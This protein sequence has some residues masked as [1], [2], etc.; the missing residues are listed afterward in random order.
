MKKL[1]MRVLTLCM[2]LGMLVGCQQDNNDKKTYLLTI[3]GYTMYDMAMLYFVSTD[4]EVLETGSIDFELVEGQTVKEIAAL[5]GYTFKDAKTENYDT[6]EGWLQYDVIITQDEQ[7]CEVYEYQLAS[8]DVLTTDQMLESVMPKDKNIC[9]TAKWAGVDVGEYY[10]EHDDTSEYF[11]GYQGVV[12]I[13]S[14]GGSIKT[15]GN[16]GDVRVEEEATIFGLSDVETCLQE[17]FVSNEYSFE[18]TKEGATLK[19]WKVYKADALN[20]RYEQVDH[21]YW[22]GVDYDGNSSWITMTNET[23]VSENMSTDDVYNLKPGLGVYY[24]IANWE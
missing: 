7:G 23:L 5:S 20:I 11:E 16:A 12:A 21:G 3:D 14:N 9:F 4:N 13:S 1:F 18:I 19:G 22:F 24:A 17:S 8:Q 6:F 2:A 10:V 15:V